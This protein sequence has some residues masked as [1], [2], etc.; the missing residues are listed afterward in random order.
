MLKEG[1]RMKNA[2]KNLL[3]KR[4]LVIMIFAFIYSIFCNNFAIGA[5]VNWNNVDYVQLKANQTIYANETGTE[6]L[7]SKVLNSEQKTKQ[8]IYKVL[9]VGSNRIKVEVNVSWSVFDLEGWVSKSS[10]DF[11][12]GQEI[13]LLSSNYEGTSHSYSYGTLKDRSN[14]KSWNVAC[15][16]GNT[17][18]I[19]LSS[20][21]HVDDEVGEDLGL[22]EDNI[23]D[24]T[25]DKEQTKDEILDK[26]N[27]DLKD[28][29][30]QELK[31]LYKQITEYEKQY[32]GTDSEIQEKKQAVAEEL[33]ARGYDTMDLEDI[34]VVGPDTIYTSLPNKVDTSTSRQSLDDMM[35]DADRFIGLG[36][37]Q[38]DGDLAD[39]SNT[40]YNI[41][42]SVGIVVAVIVGAIIGIKLMASNIDTIV[43]A[44]RLLIPYVVGCIVVFGGFGIWKI[45]VS[46]LQGM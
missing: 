16:D 5:S 9:E 35:N 33:G 17:Y 39:F 25:E 27:S 19:P 42:L 22:D 46:I 10:V 32:G 21:Y 1:G 44:K 37:P 20:I 43:E 4:F 30:D 2:T 36:N 15:D 11:Y 12:Q 14:S 23:Q 45:V 40:I 26:T 3:A 31:E 6:K 8:E 18:A 29:T 24:S 41:L 13:K 34:T 28:L 38:Y 7:K